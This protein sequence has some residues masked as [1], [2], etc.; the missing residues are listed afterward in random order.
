MISRRAELRRP[1]G[2]TSGPGVMQMA[3]ALEFGLKAGLQLLHLHADRL[4]PVCD[5]RLQPMRPAA[6]AGHIVPAAN[7]GIRHWVDLDVTL[8]FLRNPGFLEGRFGVAFW[9][10]FWPFSQGL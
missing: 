5:P 6:P 1:P 4:H 10:F 9:T 3:L 7:R 2:Q 8:A